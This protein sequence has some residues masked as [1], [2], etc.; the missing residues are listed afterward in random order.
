MKNM[1]TPWKCLAMLVL[2]LGLD[3]GGAWAQVPSAVSTARQYLQDH[4]GSLGLTPADVADLGVRDAYTSGSTGVTHVYVQQHHQGIGVYN[5]VVNVNVSVGSQVVSVGNRF[6]PDLAGRVTGSLAVLSAE[7]AVEAAALHLGLLVTEP[8]RVLG[9]MPGAAR[10]TLLSPGGVSLEP[11]PVRLIYQPLESGEVR[12]A[13]NVEIEPPGSRDWWHLRVDAATGTVL[14]LNNLVVEDRWGAPARAQDA[15]MESGKNPKRRGRLI[16]DSYNVF[17]LPAESP[18]HP[19]GIGTPQSV[20]VD[21]ADPVAS[22]FGWHD[23]DGAAGAEF[24]ITRGNNVHAYAD[25]NANDLPDTDP[26]SQPD[27]GPTLDFNFPIDLSQ[28][29][30][31]YLPGAITNL[32]YWNNIMHDVSYQYGFDE[33]SGNFQVNNY[34]RGGL[35]GDDVRAEGQDGLFNCNAFFS[36]PPEGSRPRMEMFTCSSA[37]PARDGDLDHGVIAHEYTHGISNRLTG[38]PGTVSCLDNDEQMGEGWSDFF[39][40]MMTQQGSDTHDQARGMGTYL[41]G[42]PPDGPGIRTFPYGTDMAVSQYTYD[43]IRFLSVPHGVGSVWAAMLWDLN[44]ALIGDHFPELGGG[45]DGT[46]GGTGFDPDLYNGAGGNNLALQL[47]TDAMKLQPCSPGFVDGR[48]AIIL[49]DDLLTGDGDPATQDGKNLR[50]IWSVFAR[51]GLGWSAD[52]GTSNSRSDGT[53]AFDLPPFLQNPFTVDP[54]RFD[55][56]LAS[57]DAV[58]RTLTI[59]NTAPDPRDVTLVASNTPGDFLSVA[60]PPP[61]KSALAP[62][63]S[64]T[65]TI[66]GGG[67]QAVD[68]T[69]DAGAQVAGSYA[70]TLSLFEGAQFRL[71]IPAALIVTGIPNILTD[72]ATDPDTLF[73]GVVLQGDSSTVDVTIDNVGTDSLHVTSF[74]GL[75]GT[76]FH[77]QND[78]TPFVLAPPP[79]TPFTSRAVTMIY[80]PTAAGADTVTM[81]VNSD[82]PDEGA[83]PVVLIGRSPYA[84]V[85]PESLEVQ[86]QTD[87][88][89]DATVTL[90]NDPGNPIDLTWSAGT[91]AV[92]KALAFGVTVLPDTGVLT[93]GSGQDLTVTFDSESTPPGDYRFDLTITHDDPL[94]GDLVVPVTMTVVAQINASMAAAEPIYPNQLFD[95]AINIDVLLDPFN[96]DSYQFDLAYDANLVAPL[97]VTTTGTLSDGMTVGINAATPGTFLVDADGTVPFTGSGTLIIVQMQALTNDVGPM[98]L[99]LSNF[100]FTPGVSG[101][102]PVADAASPLAVVPFYGDPSFNLQVDPFDGT[103]ILRKLLDIVTFSNAALINGDGSGNAIIDPFDG[104]LLLRHLLGII[105]CFPADPTCPPAA[106]TKKGEVPASRA[107]VVLERLPGS[108]SPNHTRVSVRLDEADGAVY[109]A[110]LSIPFEPGAVRIADVISKLPGGWKVGHVSEEGVLRV[111]MFGTEALPGGDMLEVELELL[112]PGYHPSLAGQVQVNGGADRM[113]IH[114]ADAERPRSFSLEQ[115]YPNPFN[116]MTTI[117]YSLPEAAVVTLEIYNLLGQKVRTLLDKEQ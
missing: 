52:Q 64:V 55:E 9:S 24:T 20:V 65:A 103:L 33:A 6:V 59:T 13:W 79:I 47:V 99:A 115:N 27:G 92:P 104:T 108:G 16:P 97:G 63:D 90:T 106:L 111:A 80:E 77:A 70:D 49:A 117:T 2:V 94:V 67:S 100:D 40:L 18:L 31:N 114:A 91:A 85:V 3:T 42:E 112:K 43:H 4:A 1:L 19:V 26:G 88:T 93:A 113:L 21:P 68:V 61:S 81:V 71:D 56:T 53:E 28:E 7:Q 5:A 105:P 83:Y 76:S 48:D 29:P 75:A 102:L 82:D 58:T 41:I 60:L 36:T 54:V 22:P 15:P 23:T 72:I 62:G 110:L 57:E 73:F 101:I 96:V 12:L 44:W 30:V 8:L 66:P 50:I 37:T 78:P 84:T 95:L 11:I 74:S 98:G 46:G 86:M 17:P 109:G 87:A 14:D 10:E 34:G 32:F 35:G 39:A 89:F 69:F 107:G 38:G 51:R 45:D 116:P 25:R